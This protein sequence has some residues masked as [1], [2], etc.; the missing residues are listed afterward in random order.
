V[1]GPPGA[2]AAIDGGYGGKFEG[3]GTMGADQRLVDAVRGGATYLPPGYTV[4]QT[5]GFRGGTGQSYHSHG[6]A[7]DFQIFD[8]D[9]RPIP[10]KGGDTTGM[11][12]QL[13]RGVKTWTTK[14]D[15]E[16]LNRIGYGGA[17]G[18][19]LGGGGVP[20]L[21]HYDLGGS[22]G[23]MQPDVQFHK[24]Q[25]LPDN[26]TATGAAKTPSSDLPPVQPLGL[27]DRRTGQWMPESGSATS[28]G[29]DRGVWA[30]FRRSGNIEDRSDDPQLPGLAHR[31]FAE[32]LKMNDPE[33]SKNFDA[34]A[35]WRNARM[36]PNQMSADLGMLDVLRMERPA[37]SES[38]QYLQYAE[39]QE[40]SKF[41]RSSL[42][43]DAVDKANANEI[44]P[45]G[46]IG[47]NVEAPRGTKVDYKGDNLL[48][49]TSMERSVSMDQ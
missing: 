27:Y 40:W 10:N 19:Q 29:F 38:G 4:R 9:G 21:M 3:T 47:V 37:M 48:K 30:G 18:T 13:A 32:N 23:R 20:D 12:T 7:A 17:F 28:W 2:Q 25:P 22:R 1:T 33:V 8:P 14:N 16:L 36:E 26:P 6:Q 41:D 46:G 15:P 34:N 39:R 42:D 31:R 49:A 35:E 11:Y 45:T 5:S 44:N 24:L 43:R